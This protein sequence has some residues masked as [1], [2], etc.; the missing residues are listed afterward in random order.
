[1]AVASA[2]ALSGCIETTPMDN[3]YIHKN[4]YNPQTAEK[5]EQP[6]DENEIRT[7]FIESF[8]ACA[9]TVNF[10]YDIDMKIIEDTVNEIKKGC[11]EFFWIDDYTIATDGESTSCNFELF[12]GYT[13][14]DIS[15]MYGELCTAA[16]NIIANMPYGLDDYG[17]A[18]YIHDYIAEHTVYDYDKVDTKGLGTWNTAYGC[19]VEGKA[20]CGGYSYAFQY[21][22][23]LLGIDCITATGKAWHP[24]ENDGTSKEPQGHAWN[25][26]TIDGINYWVDVTWDDVS[27]TEDWNTYAMHSYFLIDNNHLFRTHKTENIYPACFSMDNNYFVKNNLY[28]DSYSFEA[29]GNVLASSPQTGFVEIM[30]SNEKSYREAVTSLLENGDV[31]ELSDYIPLGDNVGYSIDDVMYIINVFY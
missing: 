24:A 7:E 23:K 28:F 21:M 14:E 5:T 27:N 3:T 19:L 20:I 9:T 1:M 4:D 17:K 8:E 26:I 2:I 30:F 12:G 25:Q 10:D 15:A 11:P 6:V 16:S 18:L 13:I 22:M 31:W 29:I